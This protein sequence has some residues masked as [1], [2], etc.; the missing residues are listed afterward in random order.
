MLSETRLHALLTDLSRARIGVIGD[1]CLDVYWFIDLQV[2]EISLETG[3]PT[4][5]VREQRYSLGGAGNVVANLRALSVGRVLAFGAVG[6]DP[7]GERQITLLRAC[8]ADPAG[9][10]V[11]PSADW[12]TLAYTKPYI[13]EEELSRLDMGNFNRFPDASADELLARLDAAVPSLDIVIVNEQVESGIHTDHFRRGLRALMQRHPGKRFILDARHG[14]DQYPDAILK[15]NAHEACRLCGVRKETGDVIL[16]EEALT[17]AQ[18]I[19]QRTGRTVFVTRGDRG[20]LVVAGDG[21]TEIPGLLILGKTDPVGAGDS[22]LAGTAATLA[23]GGTAAEAAQM[24]NFVAGV[25]VTKLRQTGTATPDEV[26]R[27]GGQPDYVFEP[28]LAANPR[29]ARFWQGTEIEVIQEPP[30]EFGIRYAIFDH[31]GTVSTLRQGWEEVMEPMMLRAILGD[32]FLTADEALYH[33]TEERVRR[34]IDQTTGVQ[35][36]VQMQG[37]RDMVREFG[38]APPDQILDE[39]GYKAIYNETLLE[40]VHE[41]IVRLQQGERA[42]ED[43]TLKNAVLFLR[44]LRNA[45]VKLFLASGTDEADV[46]AEAETLGYADLFEGRIFGAV[47]D[48]KIEAKRMVL[49]K[50][51]REIGGEANAVVTFGDGPV[52]VREARR[53]GSLAVGIASDEVRRF[54]LNLTKRTRLIKAGAQVVI[55]DF[56]QLAAILR[57]LRVAE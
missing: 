30:A 57:F 49:D 21:V 16:R 56:A 44:A 23:G 39:F 2:S 12:Q 1:Y 36:L 53:R 27:I 51:L 29:W 55:P 47:G 46:V 15:V 5:P 34:F 38:F 54:G 22:F 9:M 6:D 33:R 10:V 43:F 4:H 20:C 8:G 24:G 18:T 14:S 45:G 28:E 19:F 17:A 50:I 31:D 32:R 41:R 35:T 11:V 7:F 3:K 37:L 13:G 26:R 42:V 48:V 25:T 52:E 40:R